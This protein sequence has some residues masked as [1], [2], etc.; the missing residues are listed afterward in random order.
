MTS[1]GLRWLCYFF[2]LP[3]SQC[4]V[5]SVVSSMFVCLGQYW[6]QSIWSSLQCS[7]FSCLLTNLY[8]FLLR[9]C[10][11][12]K[13]CVPMSPLGCA[14]ETRCILELTLLGSTAGQ[15]GGGRQACTKRF[16]LSC[17]RTPGYSHLLPGSLIRSFIL[18]LWCII[19]YCT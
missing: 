4:G 16:L 15:S 1:V 11:W 8:H 6:Q 2:F 19:N 7:A 9:C 12:K 14:F 3:A 13:Q 5:C 10:I 17:C 18:S